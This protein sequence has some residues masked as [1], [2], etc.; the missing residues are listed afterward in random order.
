[1]RQIVLNDLRP[2]IYKRM[3]SVLDSTGFDIIKILWV[4][5]INKRAT[6]T[7]SINRI[8]YEFKPD[9]LS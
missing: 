5:T 6:E 3:E 7:E 9:A 2:P 4:D 8:D 1:M